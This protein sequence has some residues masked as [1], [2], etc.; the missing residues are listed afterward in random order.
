MSSIETEQ[1]TGNE[2]AIVGM[3][4]S[5]PK[6]KN[7]QQFWQNLY[8]GVEGISFFSREELEAAGIA[9]AALNNP[10]FVRACGT[11]EDIEMFD[12]SFF[13]YSPREA[14]LID[15][16]QRFFLEYAWQALEDAGYDTH[17]YPGLIG[18]YA[19]LSMNAYFS[20]LMY[21]MFKDPQLADSIDGFQ[22]TIAND[23]D[24]LTTRASYKLDLQ[25]PSMV[26]QTAC[27]TSLVAIHLACQGLLNFECDMALAGGVSIQRQQ[28]SGYHYSE[29][30]IY[31]P[32][33]HCR[34]FDAKAQGCVPGSGIGIVVLK[35]LT[36]ALS[37]GDSIHAVIKGTA[38]NNDGAAK[39]GYTAPSTQGQAKVI[40]E[41][42][43]IAQVHPETI[44]YVEAHGTATP[45]GD[46]IEIAALTQAFRL[47]TDK[48]G[49]CAVGSVKSNIGHLN[50]ASGVAGVIKTVLA[51]EHQT[52]PPSLHFT[53]PNPQI[54]FT[55]SPF[56]VNNKLSQWE[57]QGTT[58][59]RAGVSSFGIGGTNAHLILEEAPP[60]P[61]STQSLRPG[62][63]IILSTKTESA[64]QH[65]RTN[66]LEHLQSHPEQDLADI[67]YTLQIGRRAFD[68]RLAIVCQDKQDA[69]QVL[70]TA[71][72]ARI[73]SAVK[74]TRQPSVAFLFPGQGTQYVNM[75]KELYLT[76]PVFRKEV[77]NCARLL[78]SQGGVDL[79][80]ILFAEG[81]STEERNAQLHQTR[82]TQPALFII[83]YALAKLWGAWGVRPAAMI[84]HSIGEYVAACLA[85]VFTL[86]D[87]L[88]LVAIRGHLMQELPPGAMLAVSAAEPEIQQYLAG[89]NGRQLSIAASNSPSQCVISGPMQAIDVLEGLLQTRG[90]TCQRLRTSHAFH[91]SMLEPVLDAFRKQVQAISLQEPQTRYISNLTGTW[92]TSEQATDP[93]YWVQHLRQT[94][95]F[96]EGIEELLR[97]PDQVLLE[98][99]PGNTL[100]TFA[101]KTILDKHLPV[102]HLP[103]SSLRR[104][105]EAQSDSTFLLTSVGRLWL[106]GVEIAWSDFYAHESRLR[107]PLPTYPFE[108]QR[109]WI[110]PQLPLAEENTVVRREEVL[111]KQENN[112]VPTHHPRPG[113]QNAYIAP[114]NS[115]EQTLTTIWEELLGIDQIGI[116][117]NFFELGGHSLLA[118]Q[119]ISRVRDVLRVD[120]PL[121]ALLEKPTVAEFAQAV[122][123]DQQGSDDRIVPAS[124]RVVGTQT[125]QA[126]PLSFAQ[127]RLWFLDRLEPGNS[128]YNLPMAQRLSGALDVEALERS[129]GEMVRRHEILRTTFAIRDG[130]TVQIVHPPEHFTLRR[131]DLSG[132]P[133]QIC[134]EKA[135]QL[136]RQEVQHP[137]DLVKGPLLRVALLRLEKDDYVLVITMHHIITDA[138]SNGIFIREVSTLYTAFTQNGLSPLPELPIQYADFAA[139][140]RERLQGETLEAHL[141]YWRKELRDFVP[142]QLPTDHP[143]PAVW[144]YRG[145]G[146]TFSLSAEV[147]DALLSLSKQ[148]GVT[149][150]MTLL[151]AFQTLLHRYTGQN[152][153]VVG[154]D[155]AN[156]TRVETEAL[157]GFFV[158]LL[159]L[160]SKFDDRPTFCDLLHRVREMV[161]GAYTH[162]DLPFEMLVNALR[163]DRAM[164]RIPLVQVLFV[165][166]NTPTAHSAWPNLAVRSGS[167]GVQTSRFDLAIFMRE[168]PAGLRGSFVY[169]T[170]L[171]ETSTVKKLM[172]S[173]V[174]LLQNVVAH[175]DV[176]VDTL[177]LVTEEEK[178]QRTIRKREKHRSNIQELL[179]TKEEEINIQEYF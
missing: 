58:P 102:S 177:E 62:Y 161:L 73:L 41:A 81:E 40:A 35:R 13:G 101:R 33:G 3:V 60:R 30:Q 129:L 22:L 70:Q 86:E 163:P 128:F 67:A 139:W 89:Q 106:A 114:R 140:Q 28:K 77:D 95:R 167:S 130:E 179:Q 143:R 71:E 117:D 158:N 174:A 14:D 160:R 152:D 32:D 118:T 90:I 135:W 18:V 25:G 46:P 121:R 162:Q 119:I 136:A 63:L 107:L 134:E 147:S 50:T 141:N 36:D 168:S 120:T 146:Q 49:F 23:K 150:F 64:L 151:A 113:L 24:F 65:A 82:L 79:R 27:S 74:D 111:Q 69:I 85:G 104:A 176:A 45:L 31:S 7:V 145:A 173:F 75:G 54:D 125:E 109:H 96:A 94:V 144:S 169:S 42:H 91:S 171:F 149:L 175:P 156:R 4:G 166:Q 19:G 132:L 12:A 80:D 97:E 159:V 172:D 133:S 83:E 115:I 16:Q 9:A 8:E 178:Q 52:L 122:I 48:K 10:N 17:T 29:G 148:E 61:Q 51:L 55:N 1:F 165:L 76:E 155:I 137:F 57:R 15:P 108:R 68:H 157:I 92:I 99:G 131:V 26:V 126:F 38:C 103:I 105:T 43:S 124:T 6:A 53:T 170:D 2:I 88:K 84:G 44:T 123:L 116:Y 154:T 78:L 100:S 93:D 11:L 110:D 112:R 87:A 153:I 20:Y 164:D 98:V 127:Q 56:Y 21:A 66:L 39:I 142:L 59:R 34:T 72:P 5:F 138:W 47:Q 37:D